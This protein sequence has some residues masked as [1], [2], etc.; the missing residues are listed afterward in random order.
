M[1]KKRGKIGKYSKV[2]TQMKYQ[3]VHLVES[4]GLNLRTV[5]L[6]IFRP[7]KTCG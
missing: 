6:E 7:L 2:S 4:N 3:L 1:A 5:Y